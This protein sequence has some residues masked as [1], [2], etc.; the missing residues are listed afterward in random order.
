[1]KKI[2]LTLNILAVLTVF[3]TAGAP[4]LGASLMQANVAFAQ[5]A[6]GAGA[7]DATLK[8][9]IIPCSKLAPC[10]TPE[11][12]SKGAGSVREYITQTFGST[13]FTAFLGLSAATSVIFI[14]V[15]GFQMHLAFGGE[16]GV[17]AA[18]KTITWAIVGLVVSILSL[19]MI[20]IV[21]NIF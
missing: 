18:K 4:L 13:F 7:D 15:G 20:R 12:Q 8:P 14:I 21:S 6:N 2:I 9:N 5:A 3:A 16:E 19:A 11:T 1:M 17:G 10:V